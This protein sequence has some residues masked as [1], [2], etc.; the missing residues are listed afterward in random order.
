MEV[1]YRSCTDSGFC[2][3]GVWISFDDTIDNT[4]STIA[5]FMPR[6]FIDKIVNRCYNSGKGV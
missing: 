1:W 2:F 3:C 5:D 6:D 4:T